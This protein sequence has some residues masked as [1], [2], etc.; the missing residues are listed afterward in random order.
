MFSMAQGSRRAEGGAAAKS[1][2]RGGMA[3]GYPF[4]SWKDQDGRH[5]WGGGPHNIRQISV[6]DYG[7]QR[8]AAG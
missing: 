8:G 5:C 2:G 1:P 3:K 4:S 6:E 7:G